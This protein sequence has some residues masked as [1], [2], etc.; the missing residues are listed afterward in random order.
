ML[1]RSIGERVFEVINIIAMIFLSIITIYPYL[2]QLALSFNEGL[3]S[4]RGGITIFPRA[5]T[6]E[7]YA[8]VLGNDKV[9]R[10]ATLTVLRVIVHGVLTLFVTYS[11]AYGLSRRGLPYRKWITLFFMIPA[12]VT[13]GTIPLYITLRSYGMINSYALYI[14]LGLFTFYNMVIFRSFLQDIPY[15]IEESARIDGANDFII[16]FKIMMPMSLP[17]IATVALWVMVGDWNDWTTSLMYVTDESKY[18]LQ[19]LMMRLIK[20]ADMANEIAMQNSTVI[21]ASEGPQMTSESVKAATLICTTIP[22][23]M[24]YPFLQK[25]FIKGVTL[26]GVK[27]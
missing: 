9:I 21:G 12:Y 15:E 1:K 25:Y 7:N 4:M 16:M 20:E 18:T 22:I 5:F 24:V 23:I 10:A 8:A 13:A 11:A 3:D 17:V 14:F 19:Y 26:G 6:L 27:G 2:N